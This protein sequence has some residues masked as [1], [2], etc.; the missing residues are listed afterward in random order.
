MQAVQANYASHAKATVIC[1][2]SVHA[3]VRR[4]YKICGCTNNADQV[5]LSRT[6]PP[7][8]TAANE[9]ARR[10]Q[11]IRRTQSWRSTAYDLTSHGG[12]IV[13]VAKSECRLRLRLLV[14]TPSCRVRVLAPPLLAGADSDSN[15]HAC[16]QPGSK[17]SDCVSCPISIHLHV[18]KA[19]YK[20]TKARS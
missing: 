18:H 5:D 9:G 16:C 2:Y 4:T 13:Q 20:S 17:P 11:T 3:C 15:T 8:R 1:I 10:L 12:R 7:A 6:R 19:T 14:P